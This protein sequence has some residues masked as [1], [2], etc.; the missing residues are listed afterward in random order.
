MQV[1]KLSKNFQLGSVLCSMAAKREAMTQAGFDLL[2]VS[3]ST[4]V[5]FTGLLQHLL[6]ENKRLV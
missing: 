5:P 3:A 6:T 2:P 1:L 4:D